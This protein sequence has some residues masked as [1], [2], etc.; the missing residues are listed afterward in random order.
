MAMN[1]EHAASQVV[2]GTN[3][4]AFVLGW[5]TRASRSLQ[6]AMCGLHGHDQLLQ[7]ENGRMFL[8]CTSC[9]HES[10]GWT[11]TGRAPRLRYPGD[12]QRHRLN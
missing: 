7:V 9:G 11:S 5:W 2:A 10:P 4:I 6:S 12:Q 1:L 8:R 3:P